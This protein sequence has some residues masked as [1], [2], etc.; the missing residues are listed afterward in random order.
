MS[1]EHNT[2]SIV[3]AERGFV[4]AGRISRDG[5]KVKI[6]DCYNVRRFSLVKKDGLGGLAMRGPGSSENDVLDAQP[7]TR[8]HVLA[9]VAEIECDQAAWNKWHA[10]ARK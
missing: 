7:I 3:V 10:K 5:D 8:V 1:N 9:I 6:E 4:F 2:W